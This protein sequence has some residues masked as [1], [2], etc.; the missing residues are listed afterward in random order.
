MAGITGA[1]RRLSGKK[2][3]VRGV[4]RGETA[5]K[6]HTQARISGDPQGEMPGAAREKHPRARQ[7]CRES[8]GHP[9][10]NSL[11]SGVWAA[12]NGKNGGKQPQTGAVSGQKRRKTAGLQ[13]GA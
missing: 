9:G 5:G 7:F 8:T 13:N 1:K 4:F 2:A 6:R 10:K 12:L 3:G 11:F